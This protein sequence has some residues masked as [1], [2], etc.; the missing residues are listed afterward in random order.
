VNLVD[1][2]G[3]APCCDAELPPS[4]IKEVALTCFAESSNN[5]A[6][7]TSEKR[8]MTDAIYN[9]V[10]SN[11]AGRNS[12]SVVD[13]LQRPQQFLGYGSKEY[14][15]AENPNNFD[16]KSCDKLKE[17]IS[18]AHSSSIASIY[19]FNG[20]NQTPKPGRVIIGT[21]Y[22]RIDPDWK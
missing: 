2:W 11:R 3:L 22:F 1:P 8:A 12:W 7:G 9:R 14:K 13:I 15:K 21:H 18:A 20:F 17:C 19:S 16:K 10:R 6:E 5:S 4:P